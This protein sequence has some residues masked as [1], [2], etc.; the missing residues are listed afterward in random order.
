MNVHRVLELIDLVDGAKIAELTV[1]D[2]QIEIHVVH[3]AGGSDAAPPPA[4]GLPVQASVVA[5]SAT[6]PPTV[7]PIAA[8]AGHQVLAPMVGT[9]YR[10]AKAGGTPLVQVGARVEKGT[11][12]CVIEAMKIMNEIEADHAGT[13]TRVLCE[14]GQAVELDQPLFSIAPLA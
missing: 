5:A 6:P 14:E 8:S 12:L 10:S 13:V 11:P 7:V 4:A 1:D 9:F 2:G 3:S